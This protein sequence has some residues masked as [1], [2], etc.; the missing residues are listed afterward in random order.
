MLGAFTRSKDSASVESRKKIL[1]K[2][3][4]CVHSAGSALA[5]FL[6]LGVLLVWVS[7]GDDSF[8]L[9]QN[10]L[11]THLLL[12]RTLSNIV[13][14]FAEDEKITFLANAMQQNHGKYLFLFYQFTILLWPIF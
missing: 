14:V 1:P 3:P 9:V 2:C 7:H 5:D 6:H 4:T 8:Q 11:I 12:F 10:L 13:I